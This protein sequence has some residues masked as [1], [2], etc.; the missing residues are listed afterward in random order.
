MRIQKKAIA[1]LFLLSCVLASGWTMTL[2]EDQ[3]VEYALQN[4]GN[5]K[6][7]AMDLDVQARADKNGWNGLLPTVQVSAT[8][9]RSNQSSLTSL[10]IKDPT[11]SFVGG[12]SASW[13]FNPALITNIELAHKQYEAGLITYE[14]QRQQTVLNV[15]KLFYGLLLQQESLEL[16]RE[17]LKNT[18]SRASQAEESFKVGY[19]PELTVLQAQTAYDNAVSSLQKQ[20]QAFVQQKRTFAML[21]GLPVDTDIIL[22][23]EIGLDFYDI[24]AESSLSGLDNR[25]DIAKLGKQAEVLKTQEKAL[26][27]QVNVPTIS[28]S[29][30]YQP[31]IKDISKDWG[32]T[33]GTAGPM[34]ADNYSD[35]GSMSVTVAMNLTNLLP[36]SSSRQ[37]LKDLQDNIGK[38]ATSEF[39]L[40]QSATVEILNLLTTLEQSRLAIEN[41]ER[42]IAL[43]Q[44]VYTLTEESYRYGSTELLDV[45]DAQLQL[46]QAK[47]GRLSEQY[48]YLS[49]LLDLEYAIQRSIIK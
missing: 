38:L 48:T 40:R 31:I 26:K 23:G 36:W 5:L 16:Q 30:S 25:F 17:S 9:N 2:T 20:E 18:E 32:G 13:S 39:V 33:V 6:L 47:L 8:L 34:I 7:A 44:K 29:A 15:R 1:I 14:E 3:A 37:K 35:N 49:A 4:N 41:S 24:D 11:V 10:G 12:I 45:R 22:Q 43:S 28:L 27:M 21:L 42:S 19:V 46:D